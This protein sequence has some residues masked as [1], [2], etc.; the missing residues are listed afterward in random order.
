MDP[1]YLAE[2]SEGSQPPFLHLHAGD[3]DGYTG[4]GVGRSQGGRVPS[5]QA[6]DR[7]GDGYVSCAGS[8]RPG[9]RDPGGSGKKRG[10]FRLSGSRSGLCAFHSL[11]DSAPASAPLSSALLSVPAFLSLCLSSSF[12][13]FLLCSGHSV[14]LFLSLFLSVSVFLSPSPI[15][16]LFGGLS[17]LMELPGQAGVGRRLPGD[18]GVPEDAQH[19]ARVKDKGQTARGLCQRRAGTSAGEHGAADGWGMGG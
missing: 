17:G 3:K 4:V 14:S 15:P 18:S 11:S 9:E 10:S 7:V 12:S 19:R 16:V 1:V 5:T 2:S 13:P 6:G 8:W